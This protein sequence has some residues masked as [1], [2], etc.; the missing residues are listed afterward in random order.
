M[1]LKYA[2]GGNAW[3]SR[4]D[5]FLHQELFAKL[6]AYNYVSAITQ[7]IKPKKPQKQRKHKHKLDF[8]MAVNVIMEYFLEFTKRPPPIEVLPII[9][10]EIEK[11]CQRY[12]IADKPGRRDKRKMKPKSAIPYSY[13]IAC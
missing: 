9:F 7:L 6:I 4:K 13:K 3:I 2:I 5:E 11:E 1:H 12:T 8:T 10:A